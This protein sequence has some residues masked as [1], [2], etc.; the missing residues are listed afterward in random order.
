MSKC[1]GGESMLQNVA[2]II[3]S[4]LPWVGCHRKT[5]R[6]IID[7]GKQC[8]ERPRAVTNVGRHLSLAHSRLG[9][10]AN[11]MPLSEMEWMY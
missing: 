7:E 5:D 9:K 3:S 1:S 2:C 4:L 8:L 11:G 10:P 6:D